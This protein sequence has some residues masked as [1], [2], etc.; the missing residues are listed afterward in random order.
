MNLIDRAAYFN[1]WTH[2]SPKTKVIFGLGALIVSLFLANWIGH[3]I[4]FLLLTGL[5]LFGAKIRP[6]IYI[7]LLKLPVFFLSLSFITILLS[8]SKNPQDYLF[9]FN[10]GSFFIGVTQEGLDTSIMVFFRAMAGIA[11]M[12]FIALTTPITQLVSV[13]KWLRMPMVFLEMLILIYRFITLFMEEFQEMQVGIDIKNGSRTK[14]LQLKSTAT[15][16]FVLFRR[17]MDSYEDWNIVL[18]MK[19]Y[20]GN[21]YF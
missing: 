21:F 7:R 10:I 13:F 9:S 18:E 5:I 20:N 12:Y 17:V 2:K 3:I 1:E 19:L 6:E 11:S 14:Y 4:L 16:G 8:I 15:L